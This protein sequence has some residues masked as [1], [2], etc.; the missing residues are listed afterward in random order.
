MPGDELADR[1]DQFAWNFHHGL[2]RILRGS[3]VLGDCLCLGLILVVCEHTPHAFVI[4]ARRKSSASH[5]VRFDGDGSVDRLRGLFTESAA[6]VFRCE[7]A[8]LVVIL[9]AAKELMDPMREHELL[10]CAQD[11]IQDAVSHQSTGV[12]GPVNEQSKNSVLAGGRLAG[13]DDRLHEHMTPP[14]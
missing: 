4:P 2:R 6:P 1:G 10:R 14:R 12:A 8:T 11:D 3:L 13:D 5:L 7:A 9:S